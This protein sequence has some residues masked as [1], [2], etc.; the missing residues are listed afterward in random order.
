[1]LNGDKA[2]NDMMRENGLKK[3]YWKYFEILQIYNF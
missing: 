1:M 2:K 3:F